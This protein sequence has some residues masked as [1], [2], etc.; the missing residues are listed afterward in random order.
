MP[1]TAFDGVRK[2]LTDHLVLADR[3][4]SVGQLDGEGAGP[5]N[6]KPSPCTS[7]NRSG[8]NGEPPPPGV[9]ACPPGDVRHPENCYAPE[10]TRSP[11]NRSRNYV[12][13]DRPGHHHGPRPSLAN[14]RNGLR[15]DR[16]S[17][18]R[19]AGHIGAEGSLSF[20]PDLS[21]A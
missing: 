15:H 8:R 1:A 14:G 5:I 7:P 6:T 17:G 9:I 21:R 18:L 19:V 3:L 2:L 10:P 13:S 12:G 4:P 16:A 20:R 11:P